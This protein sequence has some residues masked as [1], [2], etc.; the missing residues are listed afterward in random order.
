MPFFQHDGLR[1]YYEE[2]G[3]GIPF[4]F[5]HGLGGDVGQPIGIFKPPLGFRLLAMDCRAHGETRPLGD[6]NKIRLNCF[7][8][9]LGQ[10][11]DHL[12]LSRVI[13]GGISM[14]AAVALNFALRYPERALGLVLSRPAWLNRPMEQN[15]ELYTFI[16][17]VIR[18]YGL[19]QGLQQFKESSQY[20]TILKQ[21]PDSANSLVGQFE[22][23]R[24]QEA[25]V[26][27]ERIPGDAPNWDRRE[28]R[29]IKV[30]TLI[31]ASRQDPIHPFEYGEVLAQ[32]IP[33]AEFGELTP[34]S[35]SK[36]LHVKGVQQFL[37]NFLM[38]H[39][40]RYSGVSTC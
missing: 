15:M 23:P 6:P 10:L 5:Q 22:N 7:A 21:S 28:W 19:A 40:S 37:E 30:P 13:L 20:S 16:A 26:R 12:E 2:R 35:V 32:A 27:L 14:G 11:L 33:G 29:L 31:L 39:F 36:E 9:D 4:V 17:Q 8:D 24:A 1:F 25:L 18:K 34:K 38:R 3:T